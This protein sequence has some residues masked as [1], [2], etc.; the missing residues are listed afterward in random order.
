MLPESSLSLLH[1]IRLLVVKQLLCCFMLYRSHIEAE[2]RHD[3]SR[4]SALRWS[5]RLSSFTCEG[6]RYRHVLPEVSCQVLLQMPQPAY[7][8]PSISGVLILRHWPFRPTVSMPSFRLGSCAETPCTSHPKVKFRR[9]TA[10]GIDHC[11]CSLT[12]LLWY[13]VY[14]VSDILK[15]GSST[16]SLPSPASLST[17]LG[18]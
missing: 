1:R 14:I 5:F 3:L 2:E 7:H 16:T 4:V 8:T 15:R 18:R 6:T 10:K 13:T 17:C 12:R 11:R 9:Y